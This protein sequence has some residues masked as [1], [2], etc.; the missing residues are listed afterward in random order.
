MQLT[1][2]DEGESLFTIEIF[3]TE[4]FESQSSIHNKKAVL[5]AVHP[6]LTLSTIRQPYN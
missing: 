2:L 3:V 4:A 5:D 6:H 1:C